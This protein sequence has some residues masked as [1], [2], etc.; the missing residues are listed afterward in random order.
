VLGLPLRVGP[1]TAGRFSI[2]GV[3][4]WDGRAP[5]RSAEPWT[6]RVDGGRISRL[7]PG[8][9]R[10]AEVEVFH[11]PG[12]TAIPGL[13]DCHVHL[14]LDPNLTNADDQLRATPDEVARAMRERAASML[15]AGIT[16]ARDLG[17]GAWLELE[18]RDRIA[19][20]EAQG[21]RLVCA[22]QPVTTPGGHCHFW[23]GEAGSA[24]AVSE[25]I[26]RQVEHS[27]DWIKVMATGGVFTKG[28]RAREPQF[29]LERLTSIVAASERAGRHVAA[30]CH[31]T[32]GIADAMRAGVR[33]IEHAS[34]AGAKGFGTA[35]DE[36]LMREMARENMSALN[37][38]SRK[39]VSPSFRLN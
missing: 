18:L 38:W 27:T 33:T 6:I 21:P 19:A 32:R 3:H 20:G 39:T 8:P 31:G 34:F 30:H 17:A 16:T 29:E 10:D 1:L 36:S 13:I 37:S 23:G 5:A 25:V 14:T 35:L 11:H 26:E 4:V 15:R 22:G 9:E 28:S 7:G 24:A 2:T 12:A